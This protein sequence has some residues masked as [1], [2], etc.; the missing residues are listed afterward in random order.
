MQSSRVKERTAARVLALQPN[1]KPVPISVSVAQSPDASIFLLSALGGES[2]YTQAY[3]EA[4]MYEYLAFKREMRADTTDRTFTAIN[5]EVLNLQKKIQE[6]EDEKVE[7]QKKNNMVF[8]QEQGATSGNYLSKLNS[9]LSEC[10][11]QLKIINTMDIDAMEAAQNGD[12]VVNLELLGVSKEYFETKDKEDQLKAELAEAKKTMRSNHP[13]LLELQQAIDDADNDLQIYRRESI[14]RLQE[15]KKALEAQAKSLQAVI[16]EQEVYALDYSRRMAEYDRITS[17]LDRQ[18]KVLDQLL[19]STQSINLNMNLEQE[20][21]GILENASPA[22]EMKENV[23]GKIGAGGGMGVIMGI[24]ILA[25]IAVFDRRIVTVD[26]ISQRFEEPVMG[27]IPFQKTADG[28]VEPLKVNDSRVMLAE[29]CRSLRS[30][31]LYSSNIKGED[32]VREIVVTSSV[33]GEGKSTVSM[34]LAVTLALT[35]A[36]TLHIL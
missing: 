7:F 33:P 21:V 27:M 35:S 34:N 10:Q 13:R 32:S 30:S 29:A 1:L 8:V 14:T 2:Q 36:K 28:V 4:A 9:Q 25:A 26:D 12:S 5:E 17:R 23:W 6:T 11:T 3:L 20:S 15:K 18:K 19:S 31:L 16:D 22:V 24:A